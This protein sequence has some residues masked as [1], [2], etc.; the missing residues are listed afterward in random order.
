MAIGAISGGTQKAAIT[1]IFKQVEQIQGGEYVGELIMEVPSN[2]ASNLYQ[3]FLNGVIVREWIGARKYRQGKMA[4]FTIIN[5]KWEISEAWELDMVDDNPE[6]IAQVV[7][8]VARAI[9]EHKYQLALEALINNNTCYDGGVF[10]RTSHPSYQEGVTFSNLQTG[11]GTSAANILADYNTCMLKYR[12]M[13]KE[14]GYS[15]FP[16][17]FTVG[18]LYPPAL[19]SVMRTN[20][21]VAKQ[22]GGGDNQYLNAVALRSCGELSDANDYYFYIKDGTYM[23]P[24][25]IQLRKSF[26]MKFKEDR[27]EENLL[28]LLG[29]AR[30]EAAVGS[31][32]V[33]TKVTNT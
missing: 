31:P 9:V 12:S 29:D 33:I 19:D 32:Y 5:R 22:A 3:W 14:N 8:P 24:V 10:F 18:C 28:K 30:Y 6:I 21:A 25:V 17:N 15:L 7:N 16:G 2:A 23:K 13:K 27:D 11:T 4:E 1:G 26:A 20:F